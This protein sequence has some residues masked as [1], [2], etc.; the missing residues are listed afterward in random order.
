[1]L[2]HASITRKRARDEDV[3]FDLVRMVATRGAG[4][5]TQA[6]AELEKL[7]TSA[8]QPVIRQIGYVAFLNVDGS[9]DKAWTLATKS[10]PALRDFLAAVPMISD[11][12]CV[13]VSTPRSSRCLIIFPPTWRRRPRR[14]KATSAD[15]SASSSPAIS[16]PDHRGGRSL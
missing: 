1:M 9:A 4:E 6:R 2:S 13:R 12:A 10:V 14:A 7:T 11:E 16:G 5:L 8:K 15:M 3:I